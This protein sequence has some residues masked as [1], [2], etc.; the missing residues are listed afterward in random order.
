MSWVDDIKGKTILVN[1]VPMPDR[2]VLQ[3]D[4][5][6]ATGTDDPVNDTTILAYEPPA[7]NVGTLDTVQELRDEPSPVDGQTYVLSG[8]LS[9]FDGAGGTW[10]YNNS[11]TPGTYTDNVGTVIV[12]TGGDGSGAYLRIYDGAVNVRWF[13][14]VGDGVTDDFAAFRLAL[15]SFEIAPIRDEYASAPT[16]QIPPTDDGYLISQD[17]IVNKNVIIEGLGTPGRTTGGTKLIFGDACDAGLWFAHPGGISAP[18]P[19][20]TEVGA[21]FWGA[22]R[23]E[24]R[25]V[26]IEPDNAGMV[27]FGIVHNV[28]MIFYHVTCQNF[29]LAG[30]FAHGQTSGNSAYG[31]PNGTGGNGTMFGNTN[32]TIYTRCFARLTTEGHGFA[33]QGNNTQIMLYDTCD[34]T[35]NNGCGFRDNSSIGNVYLNCHTA[36]NTYKVL[37]GGTYYACVTPHTS[38]AA[39]EPG[40]GAN[41]EDYWVEITATIADA[42]WAVS[43]AYRDT[44]GVN[45]VDGSAS[46]AIYSHYTEGGI[47]VGVI[48]RGP[49]LVAGGVAGASGRIAYLESESDVQVIGSN[50]NTPPRWRAL[51][52]TYEWGSSLGST[53][54]VD[55]MFQC[56]HTEDPDVSIPG[57]D[58]LELDW[59]STRKAYE[60]TMGGGNRY[61][62]FPSGSWS[63]VEGYDRA[64]HFER[65]LIVGG[66]KN[67][68]LKSSFSL[69][70]TTGAVVK[71]EFYFYSSPSTWAGAVATTTGTVGSGGVVK[72][73]GQLIETTALTAGL[74]DDEII[75]TDDSDGSK[76]KPMTLADLFHHQDALR[77]DADNTGATDATTELQAA[78]D[79][80]EAST[81]RKVVEIPA[82]TYDITGLTIDSA[83]VTL[84]GAGEGTILNLTSTTA[85]ALSLTADGCAVQDL[86]IQAAGAQTAGALIRVTA[87]KCRVSGVTL[88][89]PYN[90]LDLVS[91]ADDTVVSNVRITGA[92]ND[93]IRVAGTDSV[94]G[95][96]SL[97]NGAMGINAVAGSS[98]TVFK[99][100]HLSGNTTDTSI[101]T[102]TIATG[103]VTVLGAIDGLHKIDTE[104]AAASDD[105]DTING[106]VPGHI[107]TFAAVNSSRTVVF[108]DGTGNMLLEG[109]FSADTLQDSIT[110]LDVNGTLVELAR[111]NNA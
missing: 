21:D 92:V 36:Q 32:G 25:N 107:Y 2:K 106:T 100:N 65:G 98:G 56:G 35:G 61:L 60:W 75:V 27:D 80:A 4:L 10:I 110:L 20:T 40:V 67:A 55:T 64:P 19:Y 29:R 9:A 11:G 111:S 22:G 49:T 94:I 53:V 101:A 63:L 96:S 46:A 89:N 105:L 18:A 3:V 8:T 103:A 39:D 76:H 43:T 14:A 17:L 12:P 31:D 83:N 71:G 97:K 6:G 24:L 47:E 57:V 82:G 41:W 33:A 84:R 34:A 1:G 85:N 58:G 81:S 104:A 109:D 48:P 44:G 74:N 16:I 91:T 68:H 15:D 77:H 52:G 38:T 72:Q 73:F 30:F 42:T 37:N 69:A 90:G 45:I 28:P 70:A 23:S 93:S 66:L 54:F 87:D 62:A 108:K 79:A 78:I 7:T 102:V 95:S 86:V 88:I 5:P 50:R 59:S 13:G 99:G 26:V 51:G